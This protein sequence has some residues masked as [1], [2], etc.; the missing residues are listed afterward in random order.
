[1]LSADEEREN[2]ALVG[3]RAAGMIKAQDE[4]HKQRQRAAR[5]KFGN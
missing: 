4:Q 2:A 3:A 1:M 5:E